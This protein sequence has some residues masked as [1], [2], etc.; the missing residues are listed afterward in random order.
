[1]MTQGLGQREEGQKAGVRDTLECI[2]KYERTKPWVAR[3]WTKTRVRMNY[4]NGR[5]R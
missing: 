3:P 2:W 5:F 1:M 4:E